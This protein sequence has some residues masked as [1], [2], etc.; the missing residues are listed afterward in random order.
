M[1]VLCNSAGRAYVLK[2]QIKEYYLAFKV[3]KLKP[4]IIPLLPVG[5]LHGE[6]LE[7]R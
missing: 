6:L 2:W 5:Q 1:R 3:G 4:F 7:K